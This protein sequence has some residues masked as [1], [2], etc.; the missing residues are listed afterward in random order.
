MKAFT[1]AV[2]LGTALA[3]ACATEP[4]DETDTDETDVETD[5]TD[6]ETDETDA[7]A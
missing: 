1:W 4:T 2:V 7:A 6:A 5:E 3:A